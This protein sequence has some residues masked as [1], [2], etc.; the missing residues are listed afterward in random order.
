[1]HR[2]YKQVGFFAIP[3]QKGIISIIG[4]KVI[5][6]HKLTATILKDDSRR[7][8]IRTYTYLDNFTNA[9]HENP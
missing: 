6:Y 7:T 5:K 4:S 9:R 2:L 1:M 3:P 8:N